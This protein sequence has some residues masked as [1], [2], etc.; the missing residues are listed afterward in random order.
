M[1]VASVPTGLAAETAVPAQGQP[2]PG[3]LRFTFTATWKTFVAMA[4][5][6]SLVGSILVVGWTYRLMQR[7]A[8]RYWGR[9]S[10]RPGLTSNRTRWPKWILSTNAPQGPGSWPRRIFRPLGRNFKTGVQALLTTWTLTLPACALWQF[11]W[12][13]GWDNSFNKG[14]EQA[15]VGVALAWAG[16]GLFIAAMLYVPVAQ[17]R[18]A[19][20]GEWRSFFDFRTNR[21]IIKR[22]RFSCLLLALGYAASGLLIAVFILLPYFA[23]NNN[24]ALLDLPASEQ[25]AWLNRF[26]FWSAFPLFGLFVAVRI[27]AAR[28][29][30]A[31]MLSLVRTGVRSLD[32]LYGAER[33][34]FVALGLLDSAP[35]KPA[36]RNAA[37]WASSGAGRLIAA[38]LTVVLWF[39]LAAQTFVGQFFHYRPV[40]GWLNQPLVQAPWI[41]HVP[42]TLN[43][44]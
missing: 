17:A 5:C 9:R 27:A 12:Y 23:A 1:S 36:R 10:S 25:L 14:Y 33:Q 30:A 26:Y 28:I 13:A 8:V 15:F 7:S 20:S 32:D 44:D 38:S 35:A 4:L 39:T 37:L 21:A 6:Q 2:E 24:P 43:S 22:S 40:R 11:G 34:A 16:I 3:L 41:R 18:H 31:G 42:A 19:A 29:Y